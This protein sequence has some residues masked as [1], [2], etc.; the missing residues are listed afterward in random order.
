MEPK[1]SHLFDMNVLIVDDLDAMRVN[2]LAILKDLGFKNITESVNGMLAWT[3]AVER[4]RFGKP[5]DLI[6]S[7]INMPVMDGITLLKYLRGVE[8]YKTTPI[9]MVS[10]ENEKNIIIR[11]VLF[12]AN[13]YILKPYDPEIVRTKLIT[14]LGKG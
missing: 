7:D 8:T 2:L 11:S 1:L 14:K 6:F 13:D 12:G 5:F 4:A 9:F 3:L 10:T